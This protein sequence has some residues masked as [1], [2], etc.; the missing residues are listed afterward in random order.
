MSKPA[1]LQSSHSAPSLRQ[2]LSANAS[3]ENRL[4]AQRFNRLTAQSWDNETGPSSSLKR[5]STFGNS[6]LAPLFATFGNIDM[7]EEDFNNAMDSMTNNIDAL[8]YWQQNF[9]AT[10]KNEFGAIAAP[11]AGKRD[12]ASKEEEEDRRE[13]ELRRRRER[14]EA[15]KMVRKIEFEEIPPLDRSMLKA[16]RME[17]PDQTKVKYNAGPEALG[18]MRPD[19]RRT[20]IRANSAARNTRVQRAQNCRK[21]MLE[22]CEN[23]WSSLLEKKME[24]A[25][26]AKERRSVHNWG[27][28]EKAL[29]RWFATICMVHFAKQA[30]TRM[31]VRRDQLEGLAE[32]SLM[33]EHRMWGSGVSWGSV[34]QQVLILRVHLMRR[35]RAATC[36]SKCLHH[37]RVGGRAFMASRAIARKLRK[38]QI[39]WRE[40]RQRL[41]EARQTLSA[42][43]AALEELEIDRKIKAGG[44]WAQV[45]ESVRMNFITHELRARRYRV[46]PM[47]CLWEEERER[48][49]D[50]LRNLHA[51]MEMRR[52]SILRHS[53]RSNSTISSDSECSVAAPEFCWPPPRPSYMPARHPQH[54]KYEHPCTEDCPGRQGDYEIINMIRRAWANT[55][56]KGG[57]SEIPA[58][59]RRGL[60]ISKNHMDSQPSAVSSSASTAV[61]AAVLTSTTPAVARRKVTIPGGVSKRGGGSKKSGENSSSTAVPPMGASGSIFNLPS[62]HGGPEEDVPDEIEIEEEE[63]ESYGICDACMPGLESSMPLEDLDVEI[64]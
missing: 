9:D 48:W 8:F 40:C 16:P 31:K 5:R 13:A 52:A 38:I 2:G 61:A 7:E 57:W 54:D 6:T 51:T 4:S 3:L 32:S 34:I 12:A 59:R 24:Q 17:M 19:G 44:R 1:V 14:F 50:T 21:L 26:V 43:W 22:D 27:C 47:L 62:G 58:C 53:L 56:G 37:W 45:S 33:G 49:Q 63:L 23:A 15:Y 28:G 41:H 60:S 64:D 20:R 39:W 55:D 25:T 30:H 29:Q 18:K 42:R 10:S 35:R 11:G 36:V 46:L